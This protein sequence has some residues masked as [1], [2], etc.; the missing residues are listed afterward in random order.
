MGI[1]SLPEAVEPPDEY[2][3]AVPPA[4]STALSRDLGLDPAQYLRRAEAAQRLAT[5]RA[6]ADRSFPNT[7][8]GIRLDGAGRPIVTLE[9]GPST[10]VV[11]TAAESAGFLVET[12]DR[13][14]STESFDA[15]AEVDHPPAQP[16]P[17]PPVLGATLFRTVRDG[18]PRFCQTGFNATDRDGAAVA[19]VNNH[20]NRNTGS[21]H[22]PPGIVP[23]ADTVL[24]LPATIDQART[25][26]LG[27]PIGTLLIA[28]AD[29]GVD[30]ALLR[31]DDAAAPRF[32]NNLVAVRGTAPIAIDGITDP[33]IGAPICKSG[34]LT[35]FTCGTIT[36]VDTEYADNGAT[37][38]G[39]IATGVHAVSGEGG[40]PLI[41]GTKAV[42]IASSK[43]LARQA[44]A[45]VQLYFEP[46]R[47]ILEAEPG[48]TLRTTSDSADPSAISS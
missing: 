9:L 44:S 15:S 46:I 3:A 10:P 34:V 17:D 36:S 35:G 23:D 1:A 18:I 24:M 26:P 6:E 25:A 20:C 16:I 7:V 31:I 47:K 19:I 33:V 5:F 21:H 48:L 43:F 8:R 38:T 39:S 22:D 27:A 37:V 32:R 28:P 45:E 29:S 11:R 40:A 14:T 4:L 13:T 30:Y 2:T 12:G 42:G 41:S